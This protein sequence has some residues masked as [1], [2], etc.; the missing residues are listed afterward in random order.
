MAHRLCR[1]AIIE[2][3]IEHECEKFCKEAK[4]VQCF[5]CYR[6]GHY[7]RHAGINPSAGSVERNTSVVAAQREDTLLKISIA[8]IAKSQDMVH[9]T[10][11]DATNG[12]H[13]RKRRR[14]AEPPPHHAVQKE[15]TASS[16]VNR[17]MKRGRKP[18][19]VDLQ[20][21]TRSKK[22]NH[23]PTPGKMIERMLTAAA[24]EEKGKKHAEA[25][26]T[27]NEEARKGSEESPWED[28]A[29]TNHDWENDMP[30]QEMHNCSDFNAAQS[31]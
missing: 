27:P 18:E 15:T 4:V 17:K 16:P 9:G 21:Q 1:E 14:S 23:T 19:E 5:N 31:C 28:I 8:Q 20:I 13:R 7:A 24:E 6:F 10:S 26:Q 25:R 12:R 29:M 22:T 2:G 11:R 30:A 3:Y